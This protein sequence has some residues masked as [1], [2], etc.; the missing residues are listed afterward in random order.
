VSKLCLQPI[1]VECQGRT[2]HTFTWRGTRHRVAR[3]LNRWV[4]RTDWW[5][6]EVC[7]RYFNVECDDLVI[8]DIYQR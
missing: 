8:Y 6:Q 1:A 5:R 7:R 2:P 4:V 3:I